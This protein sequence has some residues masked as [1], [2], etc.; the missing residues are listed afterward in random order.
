MCRSVLLDRYKTT[1]KQ[2]QRFTGI[3][4]KRLIW[5]Y[6]IDCKN[7]QQLYVM[8]QIKQAEKLKCSLFSPTVFPDKSYS[9]E[10]DGAKK[11]FWTFQDLN[12]MW[13]FQSPFQVSKSFNLLLDLKY[14]QWSPLWCIYWAGPWTRR[15]QNS[16]RRD[17]PT[18]TEG[19]WLVLE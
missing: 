12:L 9:W 8:I 11:T 16:N 13:H 7:S 1:I 19:H 6:F 17:H 10:K 15:S 14:P 3:V 18:L 4:E 2:W 5:D